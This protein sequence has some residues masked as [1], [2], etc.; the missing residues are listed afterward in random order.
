MGG[1][2]FPLDAELTGPDRLVLEVLEKELEA[3]N[4]A[5]PEAAEEFDK[6]DTKHSKFVTPSPEGIELLYPLLGSS[7]LRSKCV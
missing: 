1:L 2:P 5:S 6:S 4:N 3:S 7:F